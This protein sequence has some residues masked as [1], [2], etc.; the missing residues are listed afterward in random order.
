MVKFDYN[1]QR[2]M[3]FCKYLRFIDVMSVIRNEDYFDLQVYFIYFFYE[4]D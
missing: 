1:F 2:M 3:L 4:E